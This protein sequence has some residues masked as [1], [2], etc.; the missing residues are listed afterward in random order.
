MFVAAAISLV[1]VDPRP[2]AGFGFHAHNSH[3]GN[4]LSYHGSH[5]GHYGCGYGGY[6]SEYNYG[7]RPHYSHR[8]YYRSYQPG[9]YEHGTPSSL[10]IRP[11]SPDPVYT[12]GRGVIDQS[13]RSNAPSATGFDSVKAAP[14]PEHSGMEPGRDATAPSGW[15]LLADQPTAALETFAREATNNPTKGLPKA[16]YAIAQALLNNHTRAIWAMRRALKFEGSALHYAPVDERLDRRIDELIEGYRRGLDQGTGQRGDDQVMIGALAYM[17][18]DY[19]VA[20]PAVTDAVDI[21]NQQQ[22]TRTLL[23]LINQELTH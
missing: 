1:L 14:Y 8:P 13:R 18:H 12:N 21:G 7:Y 16:G 9:Y 4:H 3:G 22:T 5:Y 6:Y 19:R 10:T 17:Q 11:E 20:L 15:A 2:S 23:E